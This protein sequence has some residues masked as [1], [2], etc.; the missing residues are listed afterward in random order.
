MIYH[1]TNKG[2]SQGREN[3]YIFDRIQ[4]DKIGLTQKTWYKQWAL[5]MKP[6]QNQ[7]AFN[8]KST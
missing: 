6:I 8:N 4:N 5:V 1:R 2:E 3:R 7:K